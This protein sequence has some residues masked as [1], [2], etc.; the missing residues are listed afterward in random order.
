MV[1]PVPLG[2]LTICNGFYRA[3]SYPYV[4]SNQPGLYS[5]VGAY[6]LLYD[7]ASYWPLDGRSVSS[8]FSPLLIQSH[9]ISTNRTIDAG[10]PGLAF[11]RGA[12]SG[13]KEMANY[14]HGAESRPS[15]E[16][17][18]SQLD[19]EP[20][21]NTLPFLVHGFASWSAQLIFETTQIIPVVADHFRH[22]RSFDRQTR[23][24]MLLISNTSLA[25]SRTT[26]YNLP[27]FTTLP[28]QIIDRV[29]EARARDDI[30]LTRELALAT[31]EHS[32]QFISMLFKIGLFRGT[33]DEI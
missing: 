24:T 21:S 28:K 1:L 31:M 17:T 2:I 33:Y 9:S 4:N 5:S 26:D 3:R 20:E 10:E 22:S 25:I 29:R 23:Q 32:R 16:W 7:S 19:D 27:Q 11:G 14:A 8:S 6:Q 15:L 13:A 12:G 18:T 30:E